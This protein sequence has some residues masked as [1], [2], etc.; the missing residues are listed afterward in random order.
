MYPR[1]EAKKAHKDPYTKF[2]IIKVDN[3]TI[4]LKYSWN[5]QY[6]GISAENDIFARKSS[7][8]I[9]CNFLV[10]EVDGKLVLKSVWN[11]KFVA[12]VNNRLR[13]D[14]EHIDEHTK[15]LVETG[16]I[17]PITEEIIDVNW[18]STNDFANMRPT[19]VTSKVII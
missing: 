14:R 11:G 3:N 9:H 19:A 8:D 4:R 2:D 5:G 12:R 17:L 7:P 10:Y 13:A 16:S 1:I 15:F 18:G 6:L